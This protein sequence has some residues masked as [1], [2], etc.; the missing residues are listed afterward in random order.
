MFPIDNDNKFL[1][2]SK[3]KYNSYYYSSVAR[4]FKNMCGKNATEY[5]KKNE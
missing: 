1:V 2:T 4:L 3:E 5:I